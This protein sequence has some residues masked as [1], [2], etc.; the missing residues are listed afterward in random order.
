MCVPLCFSRCARL[1]QWVAVVVLSLPLMSSGV[2]A[3][4]TGDGPP[5]AAA[6]DPASGEQDAEYRQLVD[7]GVA[8][9][10]R[11][12]WSEA[13]AFFSRAHQLK[14]SARTL[15]GLGVVAYE[16]RNYVEAE[17]L[18]DQALREPVHPLTA[19]LRTQTEA[20]LAKARTLIGRFR[21]RVTPADA[22]LSVDGH[23]AELRNGVLALNAGPHRLVAQR[24]GFSDGELQID[25]HGGEDQELELRLQKAAALAVAGPPG[26]AEAVRGG[27]VADARAG[28]RV[29]DETGRADRAEPDDGSI[30]E[31][32]WFWTAV[33]VVAAGGAATALVL[34]ADAPDPEPVRPASGVVFVQLKVAP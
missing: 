13:R 34:T 24:A 12:N 18:L 22:R 5:R 9:F 21:L 7:D 25:V 11:G 32:P 16:L 33:A 14:P 17:A 6:T 20:T 29:G 2:R 8:E 28:A 27:A 31:S 10:G 1:G 30:L 15:R 3:Q 19:E 4:S 26:A 23:A